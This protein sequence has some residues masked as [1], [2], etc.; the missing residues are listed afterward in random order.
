MY[1]LM[2]WGRCWLWLLVGSL[3]ITSASLSADEADVSLLRLPQAKP[4]RTA[5]IDDAAVERLR[6]G[7]PATVARIESTDA[8]A[9]VV[10]AFNETATAHGFS[11][12]LPSDTPP[13]RIELLASTTSPQAGFS[14]LRAEMLKTASATQSFSFPPTG[15]RWLMLRLSSLDDNGIA[16]ADIEV[17]GYVGPPITRY[18]FKESPAKAFDVLARLKTSSSLDISISEDEA[19]LF[20]DA[21]DGQLDEWSFA[22][23]ALLASGVL[24]PAQR[25]R[26]LAQVDKLEAAARK[27]TVD[28]KSPF[29]K[30]KQ[31]LAWMHS[32]QGPLAKGYVADQTDVSVVLDTGTYNCVSSATLYNI[33][34]RRLG[35]D[36]R[37]VEVPDHAFSVLYDGT[38]HADVE[39][40][41][42]H[43]FNPA[44]DR[45]AQKEFER[46]TGFRYIPDNH[47]D[48]RR[49]IGEAGLTAIIYYNHGVT[50]A[51][52]KR[53]HESLLQNFRAMSLDQECN[54][55]VKNAM[56]SLVNWGLELSKQG[57]YD[58]AMNVVTTG[59]ALAPQDA[60][61]LH[62]RRVLWGEWADALATK[63][64][65]DQ[66][67]A[68][69]RRAAEQVPD[70]NFVGQ[71][72]WIYIRRGEAKAE[73]GEWAQALAAVTPGFD[74]V[75]EAARTELNDWRIS[76]YLRW[77]NSE[78]DE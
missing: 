48:Q 47:R 41:T 60:S 68:V 57:K 70:G 19:D 38:R 37:A 6:D 75:D 18:A 42:P 50:L 20:A 45:T 51:R 11:V 23:A 77:A 61:L 34:G 2:G 53:H 65:D 46:Q 31:L 29:E 12:R 10:F 58:A 62:N 71:Q 49:E 3:L 25:A 30:G 73:A 22:E 56:A 27:A 13:V 76:F 14:L 59:L 26:Y 52:Q 78:M 28:A 1:S 33:L 64:D 8:A 54:S 44:R 40:T 16:V 72:A 17:L 4:V 21:R 7:S 24:D 55:A 9:E 5:V 66:A 39:T 35:L 69:L 63:G 15:C 32:D 36:L 74:K 67:L 43:G